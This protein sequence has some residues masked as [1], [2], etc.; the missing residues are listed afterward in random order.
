MNPHTDPH[1]DPL[2][3]SDPVPL[4]ECTGC[5]WPLGDSPFLF[6][7]MPVTEGELVTGRRPMWCD[8]HSKIGYRPNVVTFRGKSRRR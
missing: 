3:G 7:N 6:C 5:R 4:S 1:T 8:A 2:P